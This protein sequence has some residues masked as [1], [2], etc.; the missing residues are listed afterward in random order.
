MSWS[1]AG[2]ALMMGF[3]SQ[4]VRPEWQSDAALAQSHHSSAAWL[5]FLLG[6]IAVALASQ[7]DLRIG[8]I[9]VMA[10]TFLWMLVE[11]RPR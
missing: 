10:G 5:P 3:V 7:S 1:L 6:L 2:L 8:A 11:Q 4:L 9:A